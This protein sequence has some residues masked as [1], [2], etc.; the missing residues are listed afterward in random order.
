MKTSHRTMYLLIGLCFMNLAPALVAAQQQSY[1]MA[2]VAGA[3]DLRSQA[4]LHDRVQEAE[5]EL[6][7]MRKQIG[8]S[9][10]CW[11]AWNIWSRRFNK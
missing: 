11:T 5:Q 1:Q 10:H 3:R 4:Q 7:A 6:A 8:V 2:I 9:V